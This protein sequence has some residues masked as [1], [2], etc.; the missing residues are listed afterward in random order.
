MLGQIEDGFERAMQGTWIDLSP[1]DVLRNN[2]SL[3][4]RCSVSKLISR[5]LFIHLLFLKSH[6]PDS[7][8]PMEIW[9]GSHEDPKFHI[10]F[11]E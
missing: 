2:W 4:G 11:P 9:N 5:D 8:K 1:G 6:M 3:S 10:G 7:S